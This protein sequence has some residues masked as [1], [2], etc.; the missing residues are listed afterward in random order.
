MADIA[1]NDE[2]N[3]Q[4]TTIDVFFRGDIVAGQ[5]A[6]DVRERLQKLFKASD[7]QLQRMF[8]GRPIAIRRGLDSATAKQYR[9]TLFKAGALVEL[10]P[11]EAAPESTGARPT[12]ESSAQIHGQQAPGQTPKQDQ[13]AFQPAL[14]LRTEDIIGQ[15]EITATGE[16]AGAAFTIAPIGADMLREEDRPVV[17]AVKVDISALAIEELEGDILQDSEKKRVDP[18]DIDTSHLS[19]EELPPQ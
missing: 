7:E 16:T 11:A 4:P 18:V 13:Q 2:T 10:K 3:D 1:M 14:G 15:E 9:D 6:I 8:S 17:E 19:V 5:K 12:A